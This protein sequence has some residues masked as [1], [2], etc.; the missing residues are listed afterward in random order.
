MTKESFGPTLPIS[1]EIHQMKYRLEGETFSQQKNREAEALADN[2]EHQAAYLEMALDMRWL[3]AGRVQSAMGAPRSVTPYN[4]FVSATIPDSMEGIMRVATEAA[5]TMRLGGGIGYDFSTLRPR[6]DR[7]KSL[8]SKSSGP[9]SFMG[10]FDS[11]CRTIS[12]AGHRR[13]AQMGVLRIDHPDI[14]EFIGSKM[15]PRTTS[16]TARPSQRRTPV[17]SSHFL[18]T[19]PVSSALST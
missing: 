13:G 3:S 8:D 2:K 7:I 18:P 11:I 16:G 14:M 4:C 17:A 9:L 1:E 5:Q 10:I 19:V 6:G 12:S 15:T